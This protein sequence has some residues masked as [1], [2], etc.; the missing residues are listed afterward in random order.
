ME[1]VLIPGLIESILYELDHEE[2][3]NLARQ[4]KGLNQI[5]RAEQAQPKY[6]RAKVLKLLP[7]QLPINLKLDWNPF[8]E[9]YY[10]DDLTTAVVTYLPTPA[11]LEWIEF[12]IDQRLL[13]REQ[14]QETESDEDSDGYGSEEIRQIV[15]AVVQKDRVDC[16]EGLL[17]ILKR[18][19]ITQYSEDEDRELIIDRFEIAKYALRSSTSWNMLAATFLELLAKLNIF[20]ILML[21]CRSTDIAHFML[22]ERF[23][24]HRVAVNLETPNDVVTNVITTP[25]LATVVTFRELL[26]EIFSEQNIKLFVYLKIYQVNA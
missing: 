22:F 25:A 21:A 4:S 14:Y 6:W 8:Y 5:I 26:N 17:E 24:D 20:N 3:N 13:S 10:K 1:V 18:R 7:I 12:E 16:L 11:L 2:V 23:L 9:L 15:I 19:N